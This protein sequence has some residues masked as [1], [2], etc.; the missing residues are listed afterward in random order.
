MRA[1]ARADEVDSFNARPAFKIRQREFGT[2][3]ARVVRVDV[4]VGDDS[5]CL[6]S[7]RFY[8]PS[9]LVR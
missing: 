6:K 1:V 7:P 3:G 2:R 9:D 8:Y 5:H 4:E